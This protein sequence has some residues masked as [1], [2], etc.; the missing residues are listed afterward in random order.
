MREIVFRGKLLPRVN[1]NG[2]KRNGWVYGDLIHI[3]NNTYI[4]IADL[5][6]NLPV[7]P[8]SVGEYTG[9]TINSAN[10]MIYEGDI[11]RYR[12]EWQP[13]VSS[14]TYQDDRETFLSQKIKYAYD[15][16]AIKSDIPFV[17]DTFSYYRNYIVEKDPYNG[18]WRARNKDVIHPLTR[19]YIYNHSGVIIGNYFEN[20]DLLNGEKQ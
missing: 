5:V 12:H 3:H 20:P 11:I 8:N 17:G 1:V 4:H 10:R 14:R 7:D 9:V 6:D 16:G 15:K 19:S 13:T 2:I 18:G